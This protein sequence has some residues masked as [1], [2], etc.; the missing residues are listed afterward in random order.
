[1]DR[2][3]IIDEKIQEGYK[4]VY[5]DDKR[6]EGCD[7]WL[8]AWE[9][10]KELFYTDFA[11]DIMDLSKKYNWTRRS[12]WFDPMIDFIKS[13][14]MELYN[15]GNLIDPSYH[16]KRI[17]FCQELL[18]WC[19]DDDEFIIETR[20]DLAEAYYMSGD[21]AE[22]EKLFAEL[23]HDEPNYEEAYVSWFD[24]CISAHDI[25]RYE[26]AEEIILSAYENYSI[27]YYQGILDRI[28]DLY[29]KLDKPDKV[30]EFTDVLIEIDE[31]EEKQKRMFLESLDE[32]DFNR[33]NPKLNKEE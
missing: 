2:C 8:S 11:K 19:G 21:I 26:K 32:M 29:K 5:Q 12:K 6:A 9:E 3:L 31:Y 27:R 30:R 33:K 28:I 20:C 10:I 15:A 24:C 22:G 17:T 4:L 14:R 7:I 18:R 23:I 16:C 1:M 13:L 25:P